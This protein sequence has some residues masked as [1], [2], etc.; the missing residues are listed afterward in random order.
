MDVVNMT[1]KFMKAAEHSTSLAE[2]A[3]IL[4]D[5]NRQIVT[6]ANRS[7]KPG[8]RDFDPGNFRPFDIFRL[9]WRTA[10]VVALARSIR[11]D[12]SL[13]L[14]PILADALEEAGCDLA[15][16]LEHLRDTRLEHFRGCWALR[17]CLPPAGE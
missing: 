8:Y 9:H 10:A 17:L 11:D 6:T 4:G 7:G 3:D 12:R 16:L 5:T 2:V 13:D 14:L 15:R 1:H